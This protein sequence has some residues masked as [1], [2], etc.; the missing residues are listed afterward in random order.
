MLNLCNVNLLVKASSNF[1]LH[2]EN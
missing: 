1:W 2:E